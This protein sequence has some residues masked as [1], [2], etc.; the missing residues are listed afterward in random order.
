MQRRAL[1]HHRPAH[2][3]KIAQ[4]RHHQDQPA[5]G[6]A[7]TVHG[8]RETGVHRYHAPDRFVIR[9]EVPELVQ[10]A[11]GADVIFPHP[12]IQLAAAAALTVHHPLVGPYRPHSRIG[13]A[14][15][16]VQADPTGQGIAL[17]RGNAAQ[18]EAGRGEQAGVEDQVLVHCGVGCKCA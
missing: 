14:P 8:R 1:Q 15:G 3:V 12:P 18:E 17:A 13:F 5:A 7:G 2:Q 9:V 11:G 10:T 16:Q 6:L 4:V